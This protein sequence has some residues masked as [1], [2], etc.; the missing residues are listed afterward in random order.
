MLPEHF[1]RIGKPLMNVDAC[2]FDR[3][4]DDDRRDDDGGCDDDLADQV[5]HL[6]WS[7]IQ[8][9]SSNG[10]S[11]AFFGGA[12]TGAEDGARLSERSNVS[13]P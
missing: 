12:E 4:G 8:F 6:V 13:V 11:T 10:V 1:A 2:A 7:G 3:T 5:L 9:S